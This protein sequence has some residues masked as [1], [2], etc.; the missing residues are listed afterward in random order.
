MGN[1]FRQIYT[2]SHAEWWTTTVFS[3]S[4]AGEVAEVFFPAAP[5]HLGYGGRDG[6]GGGRG[7]GGQLVA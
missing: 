3:P 6:E 1:Y 2:S 5:G 7:G 4:Q